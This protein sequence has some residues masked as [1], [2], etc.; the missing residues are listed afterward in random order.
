MKEKIF[1]KQLGDY[2]DV[3]LPN[4]RRASSNTIAAYGYAFSIFL[5]FSMRRKEFPIPLLR[6]SS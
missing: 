3:Y 2:F 6:I 4:V 5:N 1:L